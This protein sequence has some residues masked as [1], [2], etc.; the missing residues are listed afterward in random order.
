MPKVAKAREAEQSYINWVHNILSCVKKNPTRTPWTEFFNSGVG[1]T[2]E[3]TI[4]KSSIH[5]IVYS[6]GRKMGKRFICSC[7]EKDDV[8]V[9]TLKDVKRRN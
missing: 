8:I 7:E 1:A 3:T 4:P 9:V 6:Y 5:S 2:L